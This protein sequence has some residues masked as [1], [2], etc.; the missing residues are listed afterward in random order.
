MGTEITDGGR[1]VLDVAQAR[2]EGSAPPE[3]LYTDD[4]VDHDPGEG[5]PAGG[6]GLDWYWERFG[7][8]FSDVSH[9]VVETVATPGHLVTVTN[10]SGR[11]TGEYLGHAAT[12]RTFTVRAVQVFRF[13]GERL[14]ER[15]GST[16]TEGILQQLGV[17]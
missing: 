12:G 5:Q 16:D 10:L 15:W 17:A 2:R 8:A 1:R 7:Q 11:H 6:T 4:F 9:D 3:Q 14:A 13:D